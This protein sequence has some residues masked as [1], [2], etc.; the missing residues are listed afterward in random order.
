MAPNRAVLRQRAPTAIW[1]PCAKPT[2]NL[3]SC[4]L[5]WA[6]RAGTLSQPRGRVA[7]WWAN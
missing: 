1:S 6:P 2:L 5:R 3:H 4:V 7:W